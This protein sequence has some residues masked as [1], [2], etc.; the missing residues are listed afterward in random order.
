[1]SYIAEDL[2]KKQKEISVAEFFERNRH[3]LGFDSPTRSLF[4]CVKE[5]VDNSLDACE[6]ASIL[7]DITIALKKES[8]DEYTVE[9]SD[10]G[11]G[12][13]KAQIGS[14]FGKLLYGSRFHSIKQSRGQQGIGISACVLYAQLS[15]GRPTEIATKIGE[16]M[17]AYHC[18]VMIN[19]QKNRPILTNEALLHWD[20]SSGTHTKMRI[21]GRYVREK[22]QSIYEY[23]KSTSVVNPHARIVLNES[24][25][26]TTIFE[27]ATHRLPL[28]TVE[29]KPHPHGIEVGTLIKML[30]STDSIKLISFLVNEF[31]RI[32]Y[33]TAREICSSRAKLDENAKPNRLNNDEI[34]SLHESL[35][36]TKVSAPPS[37]CLSPITETLLKK[38]VKKEI[39]VDFIAVSSREPKVY[40]GH[41]FLVES[42]IAYLKKS[43]EGTRIMRFANKVPLLYQQGDCAI[44]HAIESIDWRRYGLGQKGGKGVPEGPVVFLLHV[45]STSV[46]FTSESKEAIAD[47]PGIVDEVKGSL[48]ECA[49]KLQT[50]IKK[51]EKYEKMKEKEE[52]IKEILPQIAEKCSRFLS[53]PM[54]NL[55]LIMAKI[56]DVVVIKNEISYS[57]NIYNVRIGITNY[58]KR[59]KDFTLYSLIPKESRVVEQK[60][61]GSVSD[62]SVKLISWKIP[63]IKRN[64]SCAIE[65]KLSNLE[66]GDYE[67]AELYIKNI[68]AQL[69]DGASAYEEVL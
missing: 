30:K 14:V 28:K 39:D 9:I 3:M 5:G 4:T 21:K 37:E 65:Y 60:P 66:K 49:R 40:S 6:E 63:R 20:K 46:P 22:R 35:K 53:R 15:T 11:P 18:R 54:M 47:I 8:S 55:D 57:N 58:T 29:I 64:G 10:N 17:P 13:V 52:I 45:A 36:N 43:N 7:P 48:R 50:H 2:A 19:T 42:S 26:V 67:E 23:L 69:I 68:D 59:G 62:G 33:R 31:C 32:G 56:M 1:M 16:G 61:K 44:T 27:R 38:G 12:I 25:G 41:P 34:R 51:K 24:D